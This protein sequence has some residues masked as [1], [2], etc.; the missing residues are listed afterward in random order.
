M[1]GMVAAMAAHDPLPAVPGD[2]P[3]GAPTNGLE[4]TY[5]GILVGLSWTNADALAEIQIGYAASGEPLSVYDTAP[6]G[7]TTYETEGTVSDGW[8]V[9]HIRNG[10][11]SAWAQVLTEE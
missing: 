5:G 2:P 11:T 1:M 9:R 10:Q 8:W 6:A 7:A 3:T 4:Y